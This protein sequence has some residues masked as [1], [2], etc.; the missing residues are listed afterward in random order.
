MSIR[1]LFGLVVWLTRRPPGHSC[2][3]ILLPDEKK[4]QPT[5]VQEAASSA[6]HIW[7]QDRLSCTVVQ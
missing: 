5:T 7:L 1:L 3:M 6:V 4:H 2:Q